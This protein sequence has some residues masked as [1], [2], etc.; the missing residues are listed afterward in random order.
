MLLVADVSIPVRAPAG[1]GQKTVRQANQEEVPRVEQL[2]LA[3]AAGFGWTAIHHACAG[4]DDVI[5]LGRN[6]RFDLPV[7]PVRIVDIELNLTMREVPLSL[8]R[9]WITV[10]LQPLDHPLHLLRREPEC[11]MHTLRI[12]SNSFY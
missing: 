6:D 1:H 2:H 11:M 10:L 7:M 9:D 12:G 5:G 3:R 4:G 8:L